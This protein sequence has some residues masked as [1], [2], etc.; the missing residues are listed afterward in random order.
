MEYTPQNYA[1]LL[2]EK[3]LIIKYESANTKGLMIVN[4]SFYEKKINKFKRALKNCN[5]LLM[6]E[7]V[8]T[9]DILKELKL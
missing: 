5:I 1:D 8:L 7:C 9:E 4:E 2:Y 6:S 3:V